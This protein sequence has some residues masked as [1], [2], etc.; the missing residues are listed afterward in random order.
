MAANGKFD[1]GSFY[2]PFVLNRYKITVTGAN[3]NRRSTIYWLASPWNPSEATGMS[4]TLI[5]NG[6]PGRTM[7]TPSE[8]SVLSGPLDL[9]KGGLS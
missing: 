5:V 9:G 1:A 6:A 8:G 3:D 2:A 7:S 4:I